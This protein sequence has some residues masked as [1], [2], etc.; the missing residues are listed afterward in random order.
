MSTDDKLYDLVAEWDQKRQQGEELPAA[1]LCTDCP[2]L[3]PALEERIA[4]VKG[5]DWLMEPDDESDD[6]L[7][8]PPQLTKEVFTLPAT[9]SLEQFAD[10]LVTSGLLTTDRIQKV[11]AT[12]ANDLASK[13]IRA[14]QLT[15]YQAE[16]ICAGN[17]TGLVL[18]NYVILDKIG[19]GGMGAVFKARHTRMKRI[20]ALKILPEI[21]VGS[22][23]AVERFHREVEA[24]A[25]LEHHNIV[26]AHD[27][28]EFDGQHFLVMQ[29]A[30]G[31]DLSS[32]VKTKGRMPV[33]KAVD[34]IIQAAKGLD[35]AHGEGVIHRDIKPANLL[36]NKKGVVKILDM[37]LAR[38]EQAH[39]EVWIQN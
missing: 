38:L 4:S 39:E 33:G 15:E 23:T 21:A 27:A 10:S 18:G 29:Y 17:T 2:E 1:A 35:Y 11:Q 16:Q 5:T 31:E 6:F 7:S 34:C 26:T 20:V 22:P 37:G 8:L 32:L 19:A 13:L 12:D 3:I 25:R 24:A 14:K 36:L 28:D 9:V 30:D